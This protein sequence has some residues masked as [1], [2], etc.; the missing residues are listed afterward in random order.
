MII[1]IYEIQTPKEAEKC[2]KLGVNHI[3]SVILAEDEWR[4]SLLREV[5]KLSN[6]TIVKNSII[7]LFT[8]LD[9]I[10]RSLDY[11]QP[12][13]L[14][15][16]DSLTD[17]RGRQLE[18]NNFFDFQLRIKEKFPEIKILRSIPVPDK[19][20]DQEF[21]TLKIA[22]NLEPVSDLFL[23][24]TW[25]KQEPVSGFIGITGRTCDGQTAKELVNQSRIPVILAGGLS[26]ENVYEVLMEIT[27]AGA[28]SCTLTNLTDREGAP[29]RFKKDFSRVKQFVAEI[30]R[31]EQDGEK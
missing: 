9:N 25:L 12:D 29:V 2:I 13:F 1:Q 19:E 16:C 31:A 28:D 8:N 24:D 10:Y 7:P 21:P 22:A 26:P 23:T 30:K 20:S 11:Y 14:H 3:G 18:I 6:G 15:L 5:V 17:E 4:Q 27:P